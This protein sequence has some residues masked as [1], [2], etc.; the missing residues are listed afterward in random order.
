MLT[1]VGQ[2]FD[3]LVKSISTSEFAE[4]FDVHV[5]QY[6][7]FQEPIAEKFII[8]ILSN[9]KRADNF[10]TAHYSRDFRGLNPL[11][12]SMTMP[13]K[14][15]FEETWRLELNCTMERAQLRI[16][17]TPKFINLKQI[18]LVVSCAPS[19]DVCYIFEISNEHVLTDFGK[20]ESGGQEISRR[21]W[22]LAWTGSSSGVIKQ[23]SEKLASAA[24]VQLEAAEKRL[25]TE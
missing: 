4:F 16:T 6:G 25:A 10:V 18:M 1:F 13:G 12:A 17:F 14:D 15:A 19:L 7:R 8:R 2:F 3:D 23:I 5:T 20:F 9:E 22:K 11:L 24:R 21:W